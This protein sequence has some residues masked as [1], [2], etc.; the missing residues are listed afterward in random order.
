MKATWLYRLSAI[1][2]CL[3]AAGHTI[4]YLK[5]VPPTTDGQAALAAMNTA[6]LEEAGTKYTYG[7][8]YRGFGLFLSVYLLFGACVA[9]HLG[10]LARTSPSAAGS[11]PGTYVV[12]QLANLVISV[13]YFP[14]APITFSVVVLLCA[15]AAAV[16]V[17]SPINTSASVATR[18]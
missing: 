1:L 8:F 11:L 2:L 13:A 12:F 3:F 6:H 9:W 15:V 4:G 5:F 16:A 10:N 7:M 17:R 18:S 14:A